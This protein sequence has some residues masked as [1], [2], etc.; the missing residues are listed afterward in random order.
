MERK[1][2]EHLVKKPNTKILLK[3]QGFRLIGVIEE[4]YDD[5]FKFT[6]CQQTSYIDYDSVMSVIWTEDR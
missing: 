2:F 4:L 5:C 3:P 6:T 1:N